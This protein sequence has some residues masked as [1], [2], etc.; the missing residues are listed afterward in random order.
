MGKLLW[1]FTRQIM[2]T[3]DNAM[4]A[5]AFEHGGM[6]GRSAWFQRVLRPVNGDRRNGDGWSAGELCF[7]ISQ[8]GISAGISRRRSDKSE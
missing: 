6:I 7:L 8:R 3:L 1:R 2:P 4:L 5:A